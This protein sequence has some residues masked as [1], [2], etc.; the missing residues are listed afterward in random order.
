MSRPRTPSPQP[1]T[2]SAVPPVH[3]STIQR[4][5]DEV[6]LD[7]G[8]HEGLNEYWYSRLRN[9]TS[10]ATAAR[11]AELED[12][13]EGL[14]FASGM[15]AI[16]TTLLCLADAGTTVVAARELYGDT[17]TLLQR[18]LPRWGIDVVLVPIA[19]HDAWRRA[20]A[21]PQPTIA[22]VETISNPQLR[23]A[24]LPALAELAHEQGA[25]L[26]VDNTFATPYT[27]R[28]L[29]HGADV[30]VHSATKFLNGHADVTAGAVVTDSAT[31]TR[32]RRQTVTLGGI[33]DPW[34]ASQLSRGLRTFDLR[35][36]AQ[37]ET[38]ARL[39]EELGRHPEVTRVIHPSLT[40]HPDHDT[41]VRVLDGGACAMLSIVVGGGDERARAVMRR[42][43]HFFEATS[44]GFT[45][46]L[47]S[48][49][50]TS[51][52]ITMTPEERAAIGI[53]PG[54]LRMSI[55]LEPF[56]TLLGDLTGA[57]KED[58]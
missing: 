3:I 19:D 27:C 24:D 38:A 17:L 10:D 8:A 16:S 40:N 12:G 14:L 52:H 32:L 55:G 54:M 47:I 11:I 31:A 30:V 37:C 5:D 58:S 45:D 25:R 44:L 23:V 6:Y 48:A 50:P 39:A 33:A 28:P 43:T 21:R 15:A 9:P 53:P 7:I 49:P 35:L 1:R 57:L 34:A 51:S 22:Y 13:A 42:L 29:G 20:L 26:V 2:T 46:S 36:R 4:T 18:D 41:A 56:E